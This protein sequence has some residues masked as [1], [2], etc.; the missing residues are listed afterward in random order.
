MSD[1]AIRFDGLPLLGT[2]A[3]SL[4]VFG[5]VA[6]VAL[7]RRRSDIAGM[8]AVFGGVTIA[9]TASFFA[10]WAGQ[11][12]SSA[13]LQD[14]DWLILPWACLFVARCWYLSRLRRKSPPVDQ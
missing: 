9:M 1:I 8:S 4:I 2:L 11:G 3:L 14:V 5:L 10:Y 12:T 7:V 6:V 13:K